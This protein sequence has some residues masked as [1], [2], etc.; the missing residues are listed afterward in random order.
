MSK[1]SVPVSQTCSF[2]GRV[3]KAIKYNLANNVCNI[4]VAVSTGYYVGDANSEGVREWKSIVQFYRIAVWG[5]YQ[6]KKASKLNKGDLVTIS[7]HPARLV[8]R[9]WKTNEGKLAI[10]LEAPGNVE[11][12]SAPDGG[13][14]VITISDEDL[15]SLV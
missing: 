10:S 7:F 13:S 9:P 14:E 1:T 8:A 6:S 3:S 4:D 2:I 5:E 12:L 15:A 11:Y